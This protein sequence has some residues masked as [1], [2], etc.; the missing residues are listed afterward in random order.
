MATVEKG[1]GTKPSFR[2]VTDPGA[3]DFIRLA[4]FVENANPVDLHASLYS[5]RTDVVKRLREMAS[6]PHMAAHQG[7]YHALRL[8]VF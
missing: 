3:E 7:A 6:A 2:F 5:Q 8:F 1:I 4:Q